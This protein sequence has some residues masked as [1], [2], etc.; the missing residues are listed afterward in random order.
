MRPDA[1]SHGQRIQPTI[2]P[3]HSRPSAPPSLTPFPLLFH[4]VLSMGTSKMHK[5]KPS[6]S[7]SQALQWFVEYGAADASLL[8]DNNCSA[9]FERATF[10]E[11]EDVREEDEEGGGGRCGGRKGK[12]EVQE[13][14]EDDGAE[15]VKGE[16]VEGERFRLGSHEGD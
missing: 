1:N 7:V 15:E 3:V 8:F 4:P 12:E 11:F 14:E 2:S 16:T 10:A 9:I 6:V 5:F 13:E